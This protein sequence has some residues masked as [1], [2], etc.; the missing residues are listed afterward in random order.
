LHEHATAARL[1]PGYASDV[2]ATS[3]HN[4]AGSRSRVEARQRRLQRLLQSYGVLTYDSLHELAHADCWEMPFR[5][6]LERAVKAGRIKRLS[7]D[8]Y[9]ASGGRDLKPR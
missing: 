3:G 5:T 2:S 8:L 4:L 1:T 9:E 6:V 7:E